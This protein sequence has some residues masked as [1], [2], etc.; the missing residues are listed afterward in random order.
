[1]VNN[2]LILLVK[3]GDQQAFRKM[4]EGCIRYVYAIVQRYVSN[5]SDHQ[6]VIQEIFARTYLSI[7]TYDEYKGEFKFWIRR[8][9]INLCIQHYN[10]RNGAIKIVPIESAGHAN[11]AVFEN[12][13]KLSKDEL[14]N[15]LKQMP[16]GY[17]QVFML[18]VV[19]EYSHQEVSKMLN[20]SPETS[21]TQFH[22]AK[23]W[24]KEHISSN[25]LKT[26]VGGI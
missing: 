2:E 7:H 5:E 20:I 10:K 3:Q 11:T 21:R 14:L 8:I 13:D 15:F 9:T 16:D 1:M 25:N 22:R 26:L 24:L 12:I 4:Y 17:K 19:D 18:V 23:K 6:D